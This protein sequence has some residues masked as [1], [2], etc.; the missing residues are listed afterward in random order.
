MV[1]W[2]SGK[3]VLG[4]KKKNVIALLLLLLLKAFPILRCLPHPNESKRE[5]FIFIHAY[6]GVT[7]GMCYQLFLYFK[8]IASQS[9]VAN[10]WIW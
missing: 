8:T 4:G 3:Y 7:N 9:T 2:V 6:I 5:Y 10:S 1:G